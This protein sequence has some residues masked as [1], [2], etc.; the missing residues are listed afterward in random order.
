VRTDYPAR[1]W[2]IERG[3]GTA[4]MTGPPAGPNLA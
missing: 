2:L 1:P 4:S 3:P